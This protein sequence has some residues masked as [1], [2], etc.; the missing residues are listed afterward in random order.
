[1]RTEGIAKIVKR[2]NRKTKN[3]PTKR[4]KI[5]QDKYSQEFKAK[6]KERLR[7]WK[8]SIDVFNII[9]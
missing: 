4:L 1:M 9:Y 8:V 7:K 2:K 3:S 5:R 6:N